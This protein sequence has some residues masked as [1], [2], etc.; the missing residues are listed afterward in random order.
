M[1]QAMS[2]IDQHTI[3]HLQ[4][5]QAVISRMASN[6]LYAQGAGGQR[7]RRR[8]GSWHGV[9]WNELLSHD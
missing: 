8:S 5:V 3:A 4:I 2:E 7:Y 6:K 1:Q 9:L